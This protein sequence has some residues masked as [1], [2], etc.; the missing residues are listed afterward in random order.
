MKFTVFKNFINKALVFYFPGL[1]SYWHTITPCRINNTSKDEINYYLDFSSKFDFPGEFDQN[2][3]P[4]YEH[5]S[6][7]K[8]YHPIVICQ[9]ALGLFEI[10]QTS[11]PQNEKIRLN[12]IK[13]ADWLVENG[14]TFKEKGLIWEINYNISEYGL[15]RPWYSAM[16]QGEAMSV[17][18]RAYH[19]SG[20]RNYVG[21]AEKALY[22]FN[23]EVSEGGL[24][25]YFKNFLIY[26]EYPSPLHTVGV[27][28]GFMFSLFGLY[29]LNR[30]INDIRAGELFSEGVNSLKKLLP[31]YDI[32]SWSQYYL[33]DH[34]RTYPASFTYHMLV[35]EQLK[36]LAVISGEKVFSDY[37]EKWFGYSKNYLNRTRAL[38]QKLSYARKLE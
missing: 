5:Q 12:F 10:L 20:N 2:G 8:F 31:F 19:I 35:V 34:P 6:Q 7:G 4:V 23:L 16:A 25:N 21:A 3:I 28:N 22:P 18:M 13:Q 1:A 11:S 17:L 9:Y 32:G 24:I 36:A 38:F 33:F 30:F 29:D 14:V 27:L 37:S 26:E 15:N